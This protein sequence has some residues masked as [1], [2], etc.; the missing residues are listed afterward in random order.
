MLCGK[1]LTRWPWPLTLKIIKLPDSLKD[2][3]FIKVNQCNHYFL[4]CSPHKL[5]EKIKILYTFQ[6][7]KFR[8]W[9]SFRPLF[10]NC[11]FLI[12]LLSKANYFVL[13]IS[14]MLVLKTIINKFIDLISNMFALLCN[15]RCTDNTFYGYG[16]SLSYFQWQIIF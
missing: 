14:L 4:A 13:F 16:Y 9:V 11:I 2:C 15:K 12:S 1:N 7:Q 6:I 10:G 8:I 5:D 3:I